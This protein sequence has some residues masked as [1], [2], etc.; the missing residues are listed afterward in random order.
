MGQ[1]QQERFTALH[2]INAMKPFTILIG[3]ALLGAFALMRGKSESVRGRQPADPKGAAGSWADP[4]SGQG[5]P[6]GP[7]SM[8][9]PPRSWD[10]VD[11]ASDESFPA[12]DPPAYR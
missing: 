7:D 5:R 4:G 10:K 12:S 1:A 6:A 9:D 11:E 2:V 8:R 3:L